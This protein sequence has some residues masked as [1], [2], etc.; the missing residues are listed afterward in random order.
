VS[1]A[2]AAAAAAIVCT[3]VPKGSVYTYIFFSNTD[4]PGPSLESGLKYTSRAPR[5]N[6]SFLMALYRYALKAPGRTEMNPQM[7]SSA[8]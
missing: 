4:I 3:H 1:A 8:L 5:P 6:W 2:A 7:D